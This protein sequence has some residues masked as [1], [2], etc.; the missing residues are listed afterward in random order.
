MSKTVLLQETH[1]VGYYG[2]YIVIIPGHAAG[3]PKRY[4]VYKM[5][6]HPSGRVRVVGQELPLG[7]ARRIAKKYGAEL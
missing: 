6:A 1:R 4:T 7:H 5:P 3:R 2:S